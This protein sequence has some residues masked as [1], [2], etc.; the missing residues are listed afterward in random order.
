MDDS[1]LKSSLIASVLYLAT[2]T[3]SKSVITLHYTA[4]ADFIAE[5]PVFIGLVILTR[6]GSGLVGDSQKQRSGRKLTI[7]PQRGF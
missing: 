2:S 7:L 3:L 4:S 5:V 6:L 1:R